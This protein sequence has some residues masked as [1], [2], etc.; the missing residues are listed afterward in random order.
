MGGLL[1]ANSY[2]RNIIAHGQ[3]DLES[4]ET[5]SELV[6]SIME[7]YERRLLPE[8]QSSRLLLLIDTITN[9][10]RFAAKNEQV[11]N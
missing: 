5:N 7:L 4:F 11:Q 6:I 2:L 10:L 9:Y 8:D 1:L 3:S